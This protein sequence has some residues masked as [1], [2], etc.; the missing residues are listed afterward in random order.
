MV[1]KISNRMPSGKPAIP[2]ICFGPNISS[3]LFGIIIYNMLKYIYSQ[4]VMRIIFKIY[5]KSNAS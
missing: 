5:L 3:R 1:V 2:Y 4:I